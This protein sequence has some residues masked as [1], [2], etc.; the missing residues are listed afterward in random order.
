VIG[1]ASHVS[2]RELGLYSPVAPPSS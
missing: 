2:L 1:R